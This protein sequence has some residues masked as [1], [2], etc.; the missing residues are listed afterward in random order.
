LRSA[1]IDGLP[2]D[3]PVPILLVQHIT[4]SFLDG[5]AA[6]LC[7]S[8][9]FRAEIAANGTLPRP[10]TIYLAPA[11][12]HLRLQGQC[13]VVDQG[14]LVSAQRPSGTVLF[15]SM[16]KSLGR[17]ALAVLLT[18]MGDDGASGMLAIHAAGGMTLAEDQSTAVVYGMP[19]VAVQLGAVREALPLDRLAS[20]LRQLLS[21]QPIPSRPKPVVG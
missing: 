19:R 21:C 6:W 11:D 9:P 12:H 5:F 17:R 4:A 15:E 13:L 20:R 1:R 10:G 14:P 18:G 3:L 8:T 16:A 7:E 2:A